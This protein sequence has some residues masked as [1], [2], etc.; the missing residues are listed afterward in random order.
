M[1]VDE[2]GRLWVALWGGSQVRCYEPDGAL[3]R[4]V[5]DAAAAPASEW[6]G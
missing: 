3:L 5:I 1:T 4:T 2:R 6:H